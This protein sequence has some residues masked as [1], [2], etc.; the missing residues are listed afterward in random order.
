MSDNHKGGCYY[1][2]GMYGKEAPKNSFGKPGICSA[3]NSDGTNFH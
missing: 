1:H 3:N 2:D